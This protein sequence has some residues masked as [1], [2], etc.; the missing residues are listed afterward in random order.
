ME[1]FAAEAHLR[2]DAARFHSMENITSGYYPIKPL[3]IEEKP[4]LE[5]PEAVQLAGLAAIIFVIGTLVQ[6]PM[7][8]SQLA[9]V[10]LT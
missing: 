10:S 2:L 4:L 3:K 6:V 5:Y 1:N 9:F 8:L 7:H